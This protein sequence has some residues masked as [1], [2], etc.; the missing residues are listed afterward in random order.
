MAQETESKKGQ[1]TLLEAL[2]RAKAR[3]G[4]QMLSDDDLLVLSCGEI[5]GTY[6]RDEKDYA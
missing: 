4:K 5:V 1:P 2:E 3:I 6:T